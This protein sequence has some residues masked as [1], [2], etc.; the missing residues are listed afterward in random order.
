MEGSVLLVSALVAQFMPPLIAVIVRQS[1]SSQVKGL[2]AIVLC[3][4]VAIPIVYL[5]GQWNS[6]SYLTSAITVFTL[7][8]VMYRQFWKPSGIAPRIERATG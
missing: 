5:Q 2:V 8:A 7:T 1:W 4:L 6:E 3:L